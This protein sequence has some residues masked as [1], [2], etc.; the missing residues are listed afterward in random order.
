MNARKL[1][2]K[3]RLPVITF[4]TLAAAVPYPL[5]NNTLDLPILRRETTS[6]V[7]TISPCQVPGVMLCNGPKLIGECDIEHKVTWG[8]VPAGTICHCDSPDNCMFVASDNGPYGSNPEPAPSH[9]VPSGTATPAYTPPAST[10]NPAP[11]PSNT[12]GGSSYQ[13]YN[14]NGSP[15]QGWPV[16]SDWLSF[17]KLWN[18][19][20]SLIGQNCM[21]LPTHVP[22]N[23]PEETANLRQAIWT[24]SKRCGVPSAFALA[25]MM[26]V[27]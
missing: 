22:N 26:Y 27:Y 5:P 10:S 15:E 2:S 4:A 24:E 6:G 19:Y 17:E 16:Q 9:A 1:I 18:G 8:S 23:S 12:T 3:M 14:G 21:S 20:E 13:V 25:I 11:A 7:G